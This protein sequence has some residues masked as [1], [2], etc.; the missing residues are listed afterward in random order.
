[1][2]SSNDKYHMF[3]YNL[4]YCERKS[5]CRLLDINDKWEELGGIYMKF[6]V[7][8][9]QYIRKKQSPTDELLNLWGIQ[10]HTVLELFVL[11]SRMQHYQAMTILKPLVNP[12]YH[13]LIYEGEENLSRMFAAHSLRKDDGGSGTG[14]VGYSVPYRPDQNREHMEPSAPTQISKD[15][16]LSSNNLNMDEPV[17]KIL[18]KVP[19][20]PPAEV[21]IV[22]TAGAAVN[23]SRRD[24]G[25]SHHPG[26]SQPPRQ[27]RNE[28]PSTRK[29]S[30]AS[31]ASS[32]AEACTPLINYTELEAATNGWDRSCI[33]GRG[34]FGTVYKGTWKN[35]L[36]A[37][38]KL[39][40]QKDNM[41]SEEVLEAQRQ[42]SLR[43]LK[44]L[45]S[46]RHDN[47]LPL[48]GYSVGGEASCLVYQYMVNG[49]V[50]DRLLCRH[51]T[52]PLTWQQRHNIATGTAR[53]IQF[54]HSVGDKPL[55]HGD[56]KSANILLDPYFEPKIGD[57]GLAR[58]G[59]LQQYTHIKVSRVHGTRPYLPD[60][61]LR[62]KKFSTKVDTFSFGIVLFELATGLRAY[63]ESRPKK[64]LKDHVEAVSETEL[65]DLADVK[66]GP[67]DCATATGLLALGRWCVQYRPK[68]RPDMVLVLH[69]LNK[70]KSTQ[71]MAQRAHC[72]LRQNSLSPSN[73]YEMQLVHDHL[74]QQRRLTPPSLTPLYIPNQMVF[75]MHGS[76]QPPSSGAVQ[77]QVSPELFPYKLPEQTPCQV[78]LGNHQMPQY[79]PVINV[80]SPTGPN[81]S[82]LLPPSTSG[83]LP[84]IFDQNTAQNQQEHPELP[85][86]PCDNLPLISELGI[87]TPTTEQLTLSASVPVKEICTSS[88]SG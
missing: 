40:N 79:A 3:V 42:Q 53:G 31:I 14:A 73:P 58:E 44:Y 57:F 65:S 52:K 19:L 34:G 9:L 87:K 55:V 24:S 11:L 82:E 22:N 78:Q 20:M 71:D 23:G 49:S 54:L 76:S 61:F 60:E 81:L 30:N 28:S 17:H 2:A 32:S 25:E 37:I 26:S 4:P 5:L 59:P 8:T 69:R 27:E 10:N 15:L 35:T 80:S 38:K 67:D 83:Q 43:E 68:D 13:R 33:V 85:L 7:L 12:K 50:E 77:N 72:L 86:T 36:V 56:I 63:E 64:F 39:E 46:C 51:G 47:I 6:D 88:S 21:K 84:F 41:E 48:Y 45:N 16:G 66:A 74:S 75:A 70:L 29:L 1:M 18:P 62:G